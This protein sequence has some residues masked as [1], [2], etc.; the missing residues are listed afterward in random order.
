MC[1]CVNLFPPKMGTLTDLNWIYFKVILTIM[2]QK[3]NTEIQD[4]K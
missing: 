3:Y 1:K 2:E 4:R